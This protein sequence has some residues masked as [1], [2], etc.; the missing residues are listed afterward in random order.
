MLEIPLFPLNTVL[1]PHMPISLNIF[2]PRYK[3]MVE[4]CLRTGAPFGVVL[5]REGDEAH[6]PLA[7]PH[8][9]GC[10][11][12]I[13]QVDRLPDG[14]LSILAVGLE[15]FEIQTLSHDQP[16]LKGVV[17]PLP[18]NAESQQ[19]VDRWGDVLRPYV[20]QYLGMLAR[21]SDAVRFDPADLPQ[22]SLALAHLAAALV[23]IPLEQKQ[24]LLNEGDAAKFVRQVSR[25]YQREV[26]ILE[27]ILQHEAAGEPEG[28][29]SLN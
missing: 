25:V 22:D 28:V 21:S 27:L 17:E 8:E 23:Q 11:A 4:E 12:Q 1:F 18:L 10:L 29:F 20:E 5:I 3:L 14:R 6:G 19:E 2:E 9:V 13:T 7:E 16:Y 26:A 15:R 24:D